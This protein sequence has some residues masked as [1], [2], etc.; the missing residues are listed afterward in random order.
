MVVTV[1]GALIRGGDMIRATI[2]IKVTTVAMIV[3]TTI[4]GTSAILVV[5]ET[6]ETINIGIHDVGARTARYIPGLAHSGPGHVCGDAI[7]IRSE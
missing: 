2:M 6:T 5:I 1:T 7:C 3:E 4:D